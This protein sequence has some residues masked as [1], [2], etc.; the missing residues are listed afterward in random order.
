MDR[1]GQLS[2]FKA[3]TSNVKEL[4]AAWSQLTRSVN[5]SIR[6]GDAKGERA[7]TK[8]LALLLC[9]W[10]EATFSKL[11]HTPHG[12]DLH[13]IEQVKAAQMDGIGAAWKRCIDLGLRRCDLSVPGSFAP[14]VSQRMKRMVDQHVFDISLVRN[15]LAHGQWE[16]ALNRENTAE[17]QDASKRIESLSLVSLQNTKVAQEHLAA[18]IETLIESPQRT[19][20]GGF[21]GMLDA[22]EGDLSRR[23]TW[24]RDTLK[25][26]LTRK[27]PRAACACGRQARR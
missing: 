15:K 1:S 9:A 12:F 5:L 20:V 19:F 21:Y 2:V 13:E 22:F 14:N 7:L 25:Q 24:N 26:I 8:C 11:I 10:S 3:Q 27:Q 4:E 17:N 16:K 6:K 23:E 18:M